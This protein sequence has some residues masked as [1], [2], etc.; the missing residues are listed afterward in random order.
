[1]REIGD[2]VLDH[3]HVGKR[4]DLDFALKVFDCRGACETILA[5]HVHRTRATN[6]LATGPAECQRRIDFILDLEQG[7]QN[8]RAGLIKIKLEL[9]IARVFT[10]IGIIAIDLELLYPPAICLVDV[11]TPA[12]FRIFRKGEGCH[13]RIDPVALP[14]LSSASC[15][16]GKMA[17][18]RGLGWPLNA[19]HDSQA[20]SLHR[21]WRTVETHETVSWAENSTDQFRAD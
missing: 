15:G 12:D 19:G 17:V 8:H 5:V 2:E 16:E 3:I 13:V 10:A 14:D 4:R 21:N 7:I 6:P 11:A 20:A 9:V 18:L 1:M